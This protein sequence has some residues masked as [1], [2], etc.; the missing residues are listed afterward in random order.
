MFFFYHNGDHRQVGVYMNRLFIL[1]L[2]ADKHYHELVE[3]LKMSLELR[4]SGQVRNY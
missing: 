1:W 4:Q 3:A 2:K